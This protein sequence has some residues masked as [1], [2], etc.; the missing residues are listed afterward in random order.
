MI[1]LDKDRM[2]QHIAIICDG[3]GRWA[4]KRGLPRTFGHRKGGFNIRDIAIA[5]GE[6]GI[7]AIT[8]Y[9]FST[10]NWNRPS[11]EVNYLMT[12]PLKFMK[13][14][15]KDIMNIKGSL[16]LIGRKD[17]LPKP[18][19][20]LF[21][22]IE[23]ATKDHTGISV[24]LCVD[25]GSYDELTTAIKNICKDYKDDKIKLDDITP[26]LMNNYLMT[27]D[28]PPLDLLI[29]TSGEYRISNF[30]LWQLAYSELYFTD[31]LWPDFDK[32]EL[33]KAIANYQNRDRRFGAIKD[34]NK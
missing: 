32:D 25:Y 30:L 26:T 11:A 34:E 33:I 18:L 15:K 29:R 3:N 6:L 16:H 5:A 28:L 23:N 27:K 2:P 14:Y 31:V 17:R 4:K 19:L 12:A 8:F 20:D 1:N 22:E 21:S 10:E 9:C 13:R 7:K 24:N